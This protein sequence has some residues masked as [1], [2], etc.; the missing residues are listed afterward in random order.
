MRTLNIGAG[1]K[2]VEGA[3]NHDLTLH[4]PEINV[5]WDLNV[6]PWPWEDDSF[7]LVVACAVLEHLRINLIE[8]VSECWRILAPGGQLHMK[9]PYWRHDNSFADP[10]HYW[11]FSPQTIDIFDPDTK[12]GHD[13]A[14]YF[15]HKWR[16][17]RPPRL[18]AS[19]SSIIALL[20]VRK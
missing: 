5:A 8:S 20:E 15:E 4:R 11:Q 19:Q 10:T 13:Y 18:N 7:D 17:V 16:I 3:V 14:F 1:N 2:L 6:L 9:V 12:Y